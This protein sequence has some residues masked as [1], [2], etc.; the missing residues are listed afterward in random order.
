[1]WKDFKEFVSRGNV[2]DLAV[3]VV[4]GA[5]FGRIVT[6]L[7]ED[8]FMPPIGLLL[9]NV[10]FANLF[11]NLGDQAYTSLAQAKEAGAP[12]I[13][14]GMFVN[15]LVIFLI[16]AFVVFLIVRQINRLKGRGFDSEELATKECPLCLS[17]IP[18]N[19]TRCAYC[20]VD[21]AAA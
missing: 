7:V 11:I 19:A 2:M 10:D 8:I 15:S 14:Y 5:A 9:G 18:V 3:A 17:T 6:S 21:L 20:T 4:I 16:I 12:T 1:M 13:N